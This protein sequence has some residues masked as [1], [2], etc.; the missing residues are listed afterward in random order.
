KGHR[1]VRSSSLVPHG[2]PT[3]LFTNAGMNQFK[4]VFLGLE[5]RD[6]NRATTA[7]KC[8]R[9]GG[10]H[11]DLENVGFT[12]RHHTFFEMMGNFSFGP[13]GTIGEQPTYFKEKAIPYAWELITS[14]D[15]YGI[16]K[17]KLY[18]TVFGGAEV[19]P[20]TTLGVDE[21]ARGF[22]REHVPDERIFPIPGLKDNFWAMGDTGPCGPCSELHYDMGP[23][24]SEQGHADCQFPCDCGRYVEIWNLVFMQY[25]RDASGTLVPLPKPSIDTGMGLERVACVLQG[26]ISN[27]DTDLFMPLIG[28]AGELT[29]THIADYSSAEASLRIIADHSRATAFLISDGVVPS[30]EGRG[31]VLRKIMRRAIFHGRRLRMDRPFLFEM[32]YAVRD[33]MGGAYPELAESADRVSR[34]VLGEEERFSHTLKVG[35]KRLEDRFEDLRSL[36]ADRLTEAAKEELG[37]HLKPGEAERY[38]EIPTNPLRLATVKELRGRDLS[39]LIERINAD[40][41]NRTLPGRA[42]FEL[43]DTYGLPRDFIEDACR[44][45]GFTFD[46][47]G[48]DR[49]M[50]EQRTRARA[51]WKGGAKETAS[52]AYAKIAETFKTEKDFYHGTSAKDCRIEAIFRTAGI[53]PA[54]AASQPA[55]SPRSEMVNELRSGEAGEVVLDRTAIYADSGGQMADTGWFYDPTGTGTLAEVTG[56]YYPVGGLV[57]HKVIAKE[58]L[59][60]GD[61]VCVQA[62]A[63]RRARIIRNHSGTHLV[64]AALRNILGTHVKQAGSL[65]SPDRLRF[66]FSHFAHVDPEE[67]RDI[68]QQVNDEIRHNTQVAT[69]IT[70]IDEA[71]ASGA[72]AFF[73]DKYPESNVRVVTMPDERAPGGFYSKELCGGTHVHRIGDIGVLKIVSE[74]SVA[75]G[76]RRIEAVTGM[77]ALEHYEKQAQIL[78]NLTTRLNTGP[79]ELLASVEKLTNT[80]KQLEKDLEAQK[81]KGALGQ[82]DQLAAQVQTIKGVKLIAAQVDTIDKESLRQLVDSLRQKLGSGVVALGMADDGKVSLIA[83]VTKDLTAKVHAGKMIQTLSAKLGGKGGGRPDLAEGG[84]TDTSALKSTLGTIPGYLEGLL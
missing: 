73:G 50:Q 17:E 63:E 15:W 79:E 11:N 22:W 54:G 78:L 24:A 1:R 29:S 61:R 39:A 75:A 23:A 9:A 40:S 5:K 26:V 53:L 55:A 42:A 71:L 18:A 84:G 80:V 36:A 10:K 8:V 77:G 2:D 52:P 19:P 58:T 4:D 41:S 25:N 65:N 66:D 47:S 45:E 74:G 6:Y 21:E 82:L 67:L 48:F 16:P 44:D 49:A 32:I 83:G 30:N 33:L 14:P 3:L 20:G 70:T 38:L 69:D 62:D 12:K 28:R 64:H 60:V 51:S 81:R 27:Y 46:A 57:A 35:S 31:Y 68:E 56:A 43:Y 76:V 13:V 59:R 72:L 7:Q 37:V 34:V